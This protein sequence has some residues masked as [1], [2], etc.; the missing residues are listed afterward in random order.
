MKKQN[1]GIAI[2]CLTALLAG[3]GQAPA[4]PVSESTAPDVRME[5]QTTDTAFSE[6]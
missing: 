5:V 1:L 4:S 6:P 2:I 3:C